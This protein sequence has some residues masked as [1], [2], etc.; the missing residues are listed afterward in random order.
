MGLKVP[1]DVSL[2]GFD[3]YTEIASMSPML[4]TFAVDQESLAHETARMMIDKM[5][6][7]NDSKGRVVTG[8]HIVYRESVRDLEETKKSRKTVP[9]GAAL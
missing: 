6:G 1:D 3:D 7:L 2:V 5:H 9:S 8:G 4:T